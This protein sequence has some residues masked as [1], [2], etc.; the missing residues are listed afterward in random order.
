MPDVI[1]SIYAQVFLQKQKNK[2]LL[3]TVL[4]EVPPYIKRTVTPTLLVIELLSPLTEV[5]APTFRP[6]DCVDVHI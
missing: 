1:L 2:H 4:T 5:L 6:V 3:T